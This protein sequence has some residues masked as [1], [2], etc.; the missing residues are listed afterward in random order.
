[1]GKLFQF[2]EE[3]DYQYANDIK[4]NKV[5]IPTQDESIK[6]VE[7]RSIFCHIYEQKH[8]W[9]LVLKKIQKMGRNAKAT[10]LRCGGGV[11]MEE[12]GKK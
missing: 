8:I 12:G 10:L 4:L 7:K 1:V 11:S 3:T 2:L 9:N 5:Y 6:L